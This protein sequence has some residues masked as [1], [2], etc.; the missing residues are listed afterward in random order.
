VTIFHTDP[1]N[2]VGTIMTT[3][4][5]GLPI[6]HIPAEYPPVEF[7]LLGPRNVFAVGERRIEVPSSALP[8]ACRVPVHRR[9]N[10][11]P[12]GFDPHR[13]DVVHPIVDLSQ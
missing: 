8:G 7:D 3:K 9:D 13:M 2:Q 6:A 1:E 10:H 11:D 12:G 4:S 5:E